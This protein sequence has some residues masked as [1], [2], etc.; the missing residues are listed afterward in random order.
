[1]GEIEV[2]QLHG[3]D[4]IIVIDPVALRMGVALLVRP[5]IRLDVV[6][7]FHLHRL[8]E[9]VLLVEQHLKV[10]LH[11]VYGKLPLMEC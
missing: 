10:A 7:P 3:A 6:P 2:F 4:I 8:G 1:M 9:D 5:G 11:L